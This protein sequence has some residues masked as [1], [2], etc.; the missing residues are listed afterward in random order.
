M[1]DKIK[2]C[3]IGEKDII[4]IFEAFS[5]DIKPVN[6]NDEFNNTLLEV[7]SSNLYRM[8]IITETFIGAIS[9]ENEF[10]IKEKKQILLSIPTNQGS[11]SDA[12]RALSNLIRKAVGIDLLTLEGE[13]LS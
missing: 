1:L 3:V 10:L 11:R 7:I 8:I 12:V 13:K 6:S 9:L 2:G 4:R 5:F